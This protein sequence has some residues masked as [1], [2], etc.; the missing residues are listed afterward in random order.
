MASGK[1]KD[2]D[3]PLDFESTAKRLGAIVETLEDESIPLEES[4]KSFEEGISLVRQAQA[5][6]DEAEQR[7]NLLL[8]I[9]GQP[10]QQP[11]DPDQEPE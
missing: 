11:L 6:L 9:N 8:Q 7:V 4:L 1:K 10:S 3:K 2:T 5:A